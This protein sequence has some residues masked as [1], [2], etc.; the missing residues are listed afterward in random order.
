M[1]AVVTRGSG[2]HRGYRL[3][4]VFEWRS[5]VSVAWLPLLCAGFVVDA[6]D[7]ITVVDTTHSEPGRRVCAG[8]ADRFFSVAWDA[9][10]C[11]DPGFSA[12]HDSHGRR[13]GRRNTESMVIGGNSSC[14]QT[15]VGPT[16]NWFMSK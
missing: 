13:K 4:T 7:L 3:H 10:T 2:H 15:S 8:S 1:V 5:W 11:C 16:T 12:L 9:C 6:I 14:V